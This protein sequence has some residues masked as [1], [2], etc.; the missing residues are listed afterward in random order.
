[1]SVE[2][3]Q[4]WDAKSSAQSFSHP[5]NWDWLAEVPKHARLLDYG[6]GYGRTLAE[7]ADAG[8]RNAVGVDF[9]AGM[10]ERGRREHPQLDLRHVGELPLDEADGA[11][12]AA[13][14]V[15]VLRWT[16]LTAP[17]TRRCSWPC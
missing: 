13:L 7:L 5:V 2:A 15:A 12:D 9:S 17:S 6:C 8:R 4:Y 1:M 3:R 11:F 10:I 16:K 14:L